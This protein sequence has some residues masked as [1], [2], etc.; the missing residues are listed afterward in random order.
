MGRW[1]ILRGRGGRGEGCVLYVD[2]FMSGGRNW[3][4]FSDLVVKKVEGTAGRR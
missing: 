1:G 4:T 2:F 3:D